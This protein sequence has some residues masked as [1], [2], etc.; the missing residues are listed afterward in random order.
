MATRQ[1]QNQ[2]QAMIRLR[3]MSRRHIEQVRSSIPNADPMMMRA[4][5][6]VQEQEYMEMRR[7]NELER[8]RE[9]RQRQI[10]MQNP[11]L[12]PPMRNRMNETLK[13]YEKFKVVRVAEPKMDKKDNPG[14]SNKVD[15][16][17]KKPLKDDPSL[18]DKKDKDEKAETVT[19]N[20]GPG[21]HPEPR[22]TNGLPTS[23]GLETA[24][25]KKGEKQSFYCDLCL[26]ELNSLDAMKS[27]LLGSKHLKR[28]HQYEQNLMNEGIP[29]DDNTYIR[30]IPHP[31][32]APKKIP[33]PLKDKLSEIGNV[34]L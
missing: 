5:I 2:D 3:E 10:S 31:K 32:L 34:Q 21:D 17:E 7:Q 14:D 1:R 13:K 33:V 26:V 4:R 6:M 22:I 20:L 24:T 8:M 11:N 23:F 16:D 9:M 12:E 25:V 19:P 30:S 18:N 27:H 29:V 15:N 28:K